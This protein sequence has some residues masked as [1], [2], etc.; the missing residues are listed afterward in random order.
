MCD[1]FYFVIFVIYFLQYLQN[2]DFQF[3][4]LCTEFEIIK[5]N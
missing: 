4:H 2:I 5:T 1:I 3:R